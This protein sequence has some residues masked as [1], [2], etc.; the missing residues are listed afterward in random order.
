VSPTTTSDT[1]R[2]A[3]DT[4]ETVAVQ[5]GLILQLRAAQRACGRIDGMVGGMPCTDWV[6]G[7]R[8]G[9]VVAD[10]RAASGA[11][12]QLISDLTIRMGWPEVDDAESEGGA[13]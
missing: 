5:A 6:H 1:A 11:L 12:S 9:A 8:E 3:P 4:V 13:D 7:R 10:A 2:E